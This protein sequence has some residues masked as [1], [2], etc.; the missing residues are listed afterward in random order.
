MLRSV[1][2]SSVPMFTTKKNRAMNTGGTIASRS[3]GMARSARPAMAV[4][5]R[6][7]PA[8]P[9]R[10]VLGCTVAGGAVS[11]WQSRVRLLAGLLG[12]DVGAGDLE[13]HVVGRRRAQGRV[14]HR[15]VGGVRGAGRWL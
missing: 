3:R 11:G 10:M 1:S 12:L 13:E 4:T 15:D 6:T 7:K 2:R 14:A 9:A 8:W 5:S